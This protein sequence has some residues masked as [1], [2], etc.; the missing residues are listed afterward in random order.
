MRLI[1]LI[2]FC[3]IFKCQFGQINL[4]ETLPFKTIDYLDKSRK[5]V[6]YECS[7]PEKK[8]FLFFDV[9]S[10]PLAEVMYNGCSFVFPDKKIIIFP[11]FFT[12]QLKKKASAD[13][14]SAIPVQLLRTPA[15]SLFK[16]FNITEADFPLLVV[17]NEKNELCGF[18]RSVEGMAEIECG[19]EMVKL[20]VLRL[21]IMTEEKDKNLK[22][23]ANKKVVI[24]GGR[25]NDTI[26]KL[27]TNKYGDFNVEL[28]DANQD[29]L[30]T[31]DEK[32]KDINFVLLGT[33]TG[34]V[35]GKFK[36]TD[37]GFEYRI[38]Q[39]ELM[40]LPDMKID[41]DV[42]MQ[43]TNF[44]DKTLKDFIVTETLYYELGESSLTSGS[45]KL[46]TKMKKILDSYPDF[47]LT[48]TSH[49]DS[50]GEDGSNLNLSLK[51]S[52]SVIDYLSSL[53]IAKKRLTAEGK[54]ELEIRNRCVNGV[55]CSNKEHEYNRRTEFKFSKK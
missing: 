29:Y 12:G 18:S 39:A 9:K 47:S 43:L 41:D 46:L 17:Y 35:V 51:R 48:V 36:S 53:G 34:K 8:A 28:P 40:T 55:D 52:E 4:P 42:E 19:L 16:E 2:T 7:K 37:K 14:K 15:M 13:M 10:E 6:V 49:T 3:I 50:Q 30:I 5:K 32:D 31:V 1:F 21:K 44:K 38:L 45:K 11:Y 22:P 23:Y 54:G 27:I 25:K 33:Q 24:F 26:A 20:K